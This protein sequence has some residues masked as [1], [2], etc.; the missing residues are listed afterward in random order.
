[1]KDRPCRKE[2]LIFLLIAQPEASKIALMSRYLIFIRET[3][4]VGRNTARI[5]PSRA[6]TNRYHGITVRVF[7]IK[8][9]DE[10]RAAK[11]IYQPQSAPSMSR[12]QIKALRYHLVGT[13]PQGSDL[14]SMPGKSTGH[15]PI[16]LERTIR[17]SLSERLIH[18][19]GT[20]YKE[21]KAQVVK[22]FSTS[23]QVLPATSR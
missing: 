13:L 2:S 12:F 3:I 19:S 15:V 5:N 20:A 11:A 8:A 21:V 4:D 9:V 10:P 16:L 17:E 1:M 23:R 18:P 14:M 7:V 22:A 6:A